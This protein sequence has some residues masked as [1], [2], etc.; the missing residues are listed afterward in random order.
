MIFTRAA[1]DDD[2]GPFPKK[3]GHPLF[4][5]SLTLTIT[6]TLTPFNDR[7]QVASSSVAA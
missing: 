7:T 3:V 1:H 6:L 2:H 4:R 5:T